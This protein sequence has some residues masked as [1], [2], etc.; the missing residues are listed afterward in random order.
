MFCKNCKHS[1]EIEEKLYCQ[2]EKIVSKDF[3]SISSV[4][5]KGVPCS[6]ERAKRFF[7]DCGLAGKLYEPKE[8]CLRS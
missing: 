3:I 2:H 7:A 6:S 1:K 4:T 5:F 8:Y